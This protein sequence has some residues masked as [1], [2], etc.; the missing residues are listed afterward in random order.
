MLSLPLLPILP[1]IQSLVPNLLPDA[2]IQSLLQYISS[3]VDAATSKLSGIK[4]IINKG[5]AD[6]NMLY[7]DASTALQSSANMQSLLALTA[8][9]IN[10]YTGTIVNDVTTKLNVDAIQNLFQDG[11]TTINN[12]ISQKLPVVQDINSVINAVVEKQAKLPTLTV[13]TNTL[14]NTATAK[15]TLPWSAS[16]NSLL[17]Q[18]TNENKEAQSYPAINLDNSLPSVSQLAGHTDVL[19]IEQ[20]A[21]NQLNQLINNVFTKQ[22]ADTIEGQDNT[23][24]QSYMAGTI[25]PIIEQVTIHQSGTSTDSSDIRKTIENTL[26]EIFKN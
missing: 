23:Q 10:N 18:L 19:N 13:V 15:A 22:D 12:T 20:H 11:A 4:I 16:D 8:T 9:S 21:N 5:V 24:P 17:G 14:L 6:F 2:E 1:D 25:S 7:K 3:A 26:L